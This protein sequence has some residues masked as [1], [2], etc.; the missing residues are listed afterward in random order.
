MQRHLRAKTN[1]FD[2]HDSHDIKSQSG[3]WL[4]F[5]VDVTITHGFCWRWPVLFTF[6]LH[7]IIINIVTTLVMNIQKVLEKHVSKPSFN[8]LDDKCVITGNDCV[9]VTETISIIH[10]KSIVK[11]GPLHK[12]TLSMIGVEQSSS[13][14]S[15]RWMDTPSHQQRVVFLWHR[16]H[17]KCLVQTMFI[18]CSLSWNN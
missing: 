6:V 1:H 3:F 4:E 12:L 10:T 8:S 7:I 11:P 9:T 18:M 17:N 13:T 2:I 15:L 16:W 14:E 5:N